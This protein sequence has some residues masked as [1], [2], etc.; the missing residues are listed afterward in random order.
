MRSFL[1]LL[2]LALAAQLP[3]FGQACTGLCL[4]QVACAGSGTTSISGTVYAPNGTDPLPNVLVFIPNAAVPAMSA[5][6]SCPIPGTPPDGSPLVG[7][8]TATD[9]TFKLTNVPVGMNIPLVIQSGRWRRQLVVSSTAACADTAFSTRMPRNQSEG[10]IPHFA[11]ATGSADQVECVLRKVGIDDAEFTNP[12]STGRIHLYSGTPRGSGAYIDANTPLQTALMDDLSTL[13][14]YDVLM[15]PCEGGAYAQ[16]ANELSNL[17]QFAD[18][19]GRVYASHFS[20]SWMYQ[21]PPFD[22]VA[23]WHVDQPQLPDG[24]ATVNPGFSGAATLSAWLQVVGASTAPGQIVVTTNR[25]DLDGVNAPTQSWITLND[26]A[27]G[28][29]VMQFTF[30]TPVASANQCGRVLFNEYH[31]E[32]RTSGTVASAIRPFPT[33]C[34]N[35]AITSQEKLLEYSLFDLTNDGGAPTLT[36]SSK[37]FGTAY[38]GFATAPQTF[39]WTNHSIFSATV[40]SATVTGDFALVGNTCKDVASSA[41]C[42]LSV[43]YQPTTAVPASGTLTVVSNSSTQ[44]AALTG[45]GTQPLI[46]SSTNLNFAN[47]D[48]GATA[49]QTMTLHNAAPGSI[50]LN[51]SVQAGDFAVS[52]DCGTAL[53]SNASC[54][55]RVSFKPGTTGMRSGQAAFNGQV[56][57]FTGTGVDFSTAFTPG[58]GGVIAGLGISAP[59]AVLPISGFSAPVAL[60]CSTTAPAST[61]M[62]NT[63]NVV[64]SVNS[65]VTVQINTTS[66]YTVIGYGGA[67]RWKLA[68]LAVASG[69]LLCRFRSRTA[70]AKGLMTLVA[71]ALGCALLGGCAGK[72]PATNASYTA[73]GSYTFTVTGTDGFL[74]HT[75][76]YA[77]TV[78]AK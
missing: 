20:Y 65:G 19:G 43:V 67:G 31:V 47:T 36:P 11:V 35:A 24:A 70:R 28:N 22:S 66:K 37:D 62:V 33:E 41:S 13:K 1:S 57:T 8:I 71:L 29:P 42:T 45:T 59:V 56:A 5:G 64:P 60:T 53:A 78:S 52:S 30:N 4:Q 75:A 15:L 3:A 16:P 10:D 17:I 61:C 77:L 7:T 9:G 2:F 32:N 34:S 74:T 44:T 55:L 40:T 12:M 39:T 23:N 54:T 50:P 38:L 46:L 68:L 27:A 63:A 73:P 58:S 6:V 18:A 25:H 26:P 69:W 21:N 51:G 76:T 49:T 72:L 48:V 14:N